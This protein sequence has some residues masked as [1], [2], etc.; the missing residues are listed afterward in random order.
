MEVPE[1]LKDTI[2]AGEEV[3]SIFSGNYSKKAKNRLSIGGA[4]M[5]LTTEKLLVEGKKDIEKIFLTN[6]LNVD[7]SKNKIMLN[8]FSRDGT[9]E[10]KIQVEIKKEKDEKKKEFEERCNKIKTNFE[11]FLD[12]AASSLP[13]TEKKETPELT[14]PRPY[15]TIIIPKP[16]SA[17]KVFCFS[18]GEKMPPAGKFCAKCGQKVK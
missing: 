15:P 16:M 18:C 5:I 2:S 4:L 10:V 7:Q 9:E 14:P 8:N 3:L 17:Q 1:H 13:D 11:R 12:D 6:I